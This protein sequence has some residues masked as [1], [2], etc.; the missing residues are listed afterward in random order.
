MEKGQ[1]KTGI[2]I[3][4]GVDINVRLGFRADA[5]MIF[6][7]TNLN[8]LY[9]FRCLADEDGISDTALGALVAATSTGINLIQIDGA[10]GDETVTVVEANSVKGMFA[11]GFRLESDAIPNADAALLHY[12]AFGGASKYIRGVHDGTTSS[13][14][15]EDS[16]LDF[17]ELGVT[18]GWV[19]V[20]LSN[21]NRC[22]VNEIQRPTG[23]TRYCRLTVP[24]T[25]AAADFDTADVVFIMP[26]EEEQITA[27]TAMA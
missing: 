24:S 8:Q 20:N 12:M 6:D 1:V 25:V 10:V 22:L 15:F 13:N 16:S 7:V 2:I 23:K 4:T 14:Y 27:I 18:A 17:R 26:P 9:W 19:M 3:G 5:I 11:N 21:D